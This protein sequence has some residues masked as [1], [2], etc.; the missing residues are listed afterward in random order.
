MWMVR[1]GGK[2]QGSEGDHGREEEVESA[3]VRKGESV[4]VFD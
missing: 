2:K 3:L 1:G 4:P